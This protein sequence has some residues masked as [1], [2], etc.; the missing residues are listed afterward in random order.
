MKT[1]PIHL[2]EQRHAEVVRYAA[3][4]GMTVVAATDE[5][6][7]IGLRRRAALK[8]FNKKARAK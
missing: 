3:A 1:K 6:L 4:T 8:R 7:A 2:K 5:L